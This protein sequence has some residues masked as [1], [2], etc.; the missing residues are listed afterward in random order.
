MR[1]CFFL[2]ALISPVFCQDAPV[3]LPK[4]DQSKPK[5]IRTEHY[6]PNGRLVRVVEQPVSESKRIIA[7][8]RGLFGFV[9]EVIYEDGTHV[10]YAP[11]NGGVTSIRRP[12]K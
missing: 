1:V 6:D 8:R 11:A 2:M 9:R 12:V 10:K 3:P 7:V 5:M 4:S